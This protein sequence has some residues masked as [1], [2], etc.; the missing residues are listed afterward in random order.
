M[1]AVGGSCIQTPQTA[2]AGIRFEKRIF[3]EACSP[4]RKEF[5]ETADIQSV[6]YGLAQY[7]RLNEVNNTK[8]IVHY[9]IQGKIDP[10][11]LDSVYGVY[12]PGWEM[13]DVRG[14]VFAFLK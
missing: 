5:H 6:G 8:C 13:I 4:A 1:H 2:F 9:S 11:F 12:S 7:G 3:C 10:S 14:H